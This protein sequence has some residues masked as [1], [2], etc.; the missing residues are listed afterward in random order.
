MKTVKWLVTIGVTFA[1]FATVVKGFTINGTY[2]P[3][4]GFP[5]ATQVL[6][7]TAGSGT[8]NN[9]GDIG[10]ADSS[11]LDAGYGVITN[12]VLYLFFAG[13]LNTVRKRRHPVHKRVQHVRQTECLYHE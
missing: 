6:G 4:F 2:D 1:L 3:G 8:E 9:I 12:G 10:A 7:T 13:A 5:L 11:E